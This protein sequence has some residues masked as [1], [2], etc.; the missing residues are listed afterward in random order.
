MYHLCIEDYTVYNSR[1]SK[2]VK[3][4]IEIYEIIIV[5]INVVMSI[6]CLKYSSHNLR[7]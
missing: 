1:Y 4:V 2:L 6:Q 3:S 7:V 5:L